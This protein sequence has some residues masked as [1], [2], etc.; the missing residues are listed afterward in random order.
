MPQASVCRVRMAQKPCCLRVPFWS[1]PAP[2]QI[3][4]WRVKTAVSASTANTLR[5]SIQLARR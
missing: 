3:P 5:Q 1:P 4:C 2:S